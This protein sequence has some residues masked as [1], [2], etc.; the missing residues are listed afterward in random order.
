MSG[1]IRR[2]V[3]GPSPAGNNK[4]YSSHISKHHH[5]HQDNTPPP[6]NKPTTNK[7]QQDDDVDV[8][9]RAK[10]L[11][12][13]QSMNASCS[14]DVSSDSSFQSRAS[15]SSRGRGRRKQ[16]QPS[17]E[18]VLDDASLSSPAHPHTKRCAW[19]TTNT[20]PCYVAFHDEEWG[21]PVHD[22]KRLFELLVFSG[23][24]AELT[25]P[26]ILRKRH[27]FREVFVGFDP[28]CVSQLNEKRMM[29]AGSTARSLLSELKLRAV[30]ENARQITKIIKE[31]GS[32]E[33]YIWSF[34][35]YK[36]I[37][38]SFRYGRQ[39][40]AKNSKAD[41]ISKDLL[42]RGFMSVSATVIYSFMQAAGITNDHLMTCF[43]YHECIN[44]LHID[45]VKE[46]EE[47]KAVVVEGTKAVE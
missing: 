3:L 35:N 5:H 27:M 13:L 40:P 31:Y 30:I 23:A 45:D 21:V 38:N 16:Q 7:K 34:V 47:E 2:S 15:N 17:S 43:R 10:S 4:S 46:E 37:V 28:V 12:Q 14:S 6:N 8:G 42:K 25:W 22:D 44:H 41:V 1:G 39:V 32:F 20:E 11:L 18:A 36:P 9:K 24:L 29:G 19:V 26:T 33:L